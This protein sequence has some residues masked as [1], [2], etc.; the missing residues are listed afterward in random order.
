MPY[1][2]HLII[3]NRQKIK[4]IGFRNLHVPIPFGSP[5]LPLQTPNKGEKH[6]KRA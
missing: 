3:V 4:K 5:P 1:I 6:I 2:G